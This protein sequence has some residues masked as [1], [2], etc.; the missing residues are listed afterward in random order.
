MRT[1]CLHGVSDVC[2]DSPSCCCAY[3]LVNLIVIH[4]NAVTPTTRPINLVLLTIHTSIPCSIAQI[5]YN[6]PRDRSRCTYPSGGTRN[7]RLLIRKIKSRDDPRCSSINSTQPYIPFGRLIF[8]LYHTD[9]T[10]LQSTNHQTDSSEF[11]S[12]ITPFS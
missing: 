8:I 5:I 3:Q 7:M 12:A 1:R 11:Q 6:K 9:Q 10:G 4:P 2:K